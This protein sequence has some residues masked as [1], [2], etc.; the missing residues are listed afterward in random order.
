MKIL[1]NGWLLIERK[2]LIRI[3]GRIRFKKIGESDIIRN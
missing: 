2:V 1:I 3:F